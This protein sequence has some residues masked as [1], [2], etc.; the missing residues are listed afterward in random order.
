MKYFYFSGKFVF[1]SQAKISIMTHAFNYGTAVFEGIRAYWNPKHNQLYVFRLQGHYLRMQKN[2]KLLNLALPFDIKAMC[3]ITLKLLRKNKVKEDVYLRPICFQARLG[4]G[5]KFAG[6]SDFVIYLLPLPSRLDSPKP[7]R[8][9]VSSYRRIEKSMIPASAKISGSYVNSFLA[10]QEA[11]KKD[12]NDCIMLNSDDTVAEATGTNIFIVTKNVLL[13]P[14]VSANILPGITRDCVIELAKK[15][16]RLKVKEKNL[17]AAEVKSA[18][19][20]FLTGT[21]A[22]IVPVGQIDGKIIRNGK[23]GPVTRMLSD[24]YRRTVSGEINKYNNW[25][26]SVY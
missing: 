3:E 7:W 4:I 10:G 17:R 2:C 1:S 6:K 24:L 9:L 23:M 5:P 12:Y 19:E 20:V 21:G 16:L 13:T 18:D 11:L 22:E 14:P 8:L 15:E 25:L 26:T